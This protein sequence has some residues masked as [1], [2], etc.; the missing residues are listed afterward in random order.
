MFSS[1]TTF[2]ALP[3]LVAFCY[4]FFKSFI[5]NNNVPPLSPPHPYR[6]LENFLSTEDHQKLMSLLQQIKDFPAARSDWT[7]TNHWSH[8]GEAM[9]PIIDSFDPTTNK[10]TYTCPEREKYQYLVYNDQIHKCVFANRIDIARHFIL[11]GGYDGW[12]EKFKIIASRLLLYNNFQFN[13]SAEPEF[14]KLFTDK[15]FVQS[16]NDICGKDRPYFRPYQLSLIMQMP[17]QNVPA[18]LDIPYFH[19]AS[20]YLFP[21][22]LLLVMQDSGLFKDRRIP[23][24]QALVYLH[25]WKDWNNDNFESRHGEFVFWPKGVNYE[26][27][28]IV[29][30]PRSAIFCDG[31]EA[32]HATAT[33]KFSC[34]CF[35]I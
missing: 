11:T 14:V 27:K 16:V 12:K 21:Q 29:V 33:Y 15:Q 13:T 1:K 10:T 3:V 17:G 23:Q 35:F 6:T 32:V 31:S 4:Y 22:W 19:G 34:C 24:V 26:A 20:R 7:S 28:P 18:H 9:D 30:K 8:I 25:N 5:S 2:A